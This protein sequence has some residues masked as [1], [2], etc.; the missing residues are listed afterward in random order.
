MQKK[1][2]KKVLKVATFD[3]NLGVHFRVKG[4]SGDTTHRIQSSGLRM[5]NAER[6]L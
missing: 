5:H 3:R 4:R 6:R 1:H 2:S